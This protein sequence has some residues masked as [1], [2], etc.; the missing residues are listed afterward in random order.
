MHGVHP[1]CA[2]ELRWPPRRYPCRVALRCVS[3]RAQPCVC[4]RVRFKCVTG[5]LTPL[6]LQVLLASVSGDESA[7][8]FA[9]SEGVCVAAF[10]ARC[11]RCAASCARL[12]HFQERPALSM[13]CCRSKNY[14]RLSAQFRA[15][16]RMSRRAALS[17]RSAHA[18]L[19]LLT[20]ACRGAT[21]AR[22]MG[23]AGEPPTLGRSRGNERCAR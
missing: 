3:E 4:V 20:S 7:V 14:A 9:T 6:P 5:R 18:L 22:A 17:A 8:A 19:S 10:H 16:P 11:V 13:S 23:C 2:T 15:A 1:R 12:L 21:L